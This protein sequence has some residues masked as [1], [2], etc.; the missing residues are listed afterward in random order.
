MSFLPAPNI[1]LSR[2]S[3]DELKSLRTHLEI[4]HAKSVARQAHISELLKNVTKRM[5]GKDYSK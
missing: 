5:D 3:I 2:L 4:E 1:D